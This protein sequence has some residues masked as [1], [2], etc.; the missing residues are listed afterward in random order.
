MR[1]TFV[2]KIK[3]YNPLNDSSYSKMVIDDTFHE[4]KSSLEPHGFKVKT[5]R[6][7]Y[8]NILGGDYHQSVTVFD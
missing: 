8:R 4:I 2:E 7:R 6:Q 3:V 1:E 5:L